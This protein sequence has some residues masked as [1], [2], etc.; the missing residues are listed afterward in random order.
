M[1]TFKFFQKPTIRPKAD[2]YDAIVMEIIR[3][4][5]R[6]RSNVLEIVRHFSEGDTRGHLKRMKIVTINRRT[7]YS[8]D[9]I[10]SI[11]STIETIETGAVMYHYTHISEEYYYETIHRVVPLP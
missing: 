3:E 5:C 4:S 7:N 1:E 8:Q 6:H 2:H 9:R 11:L 10:I